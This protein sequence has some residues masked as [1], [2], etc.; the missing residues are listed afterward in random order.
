MIVMFLSWWTATVLNRPT[1][2]PRSTKRPP[3]R[4]A[5]VS[6]GKLVGLVPE[7]EEEWTLTFRKGRYDSSERKAW[8]ARAVCRVRRRGA[9]L[10][11]FEAERMTV[12]FDEKRMKMDGKVSVKMPRRGWTVQ[13]PSAEWNW[14]TGD[15]TGPGPVK[16]EGSRLSAVG[17]GLIGNTS[18][19]EITLAGEVMLQWHRL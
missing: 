11:I 5:E 12:R 15:L 9:V 19:M 14:Q 1:A 10:A 8:V 3:S 16:V 2:G 6:Q 13:L 17:Q 18:Q 7:R 4:F